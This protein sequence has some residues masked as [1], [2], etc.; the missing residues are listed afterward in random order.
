MKPSI[1]QGMKSSFNI[2]YSGQDTDRRCII[3]MPS[4]IKTLQNPVAITREK[5]EEID[6]TSKNLSKKKS[7]AIEIEDEEYLRLKDK[8]KNPLTITDAD[9][10]AFTGVLQDTN[11][12]GLNLNENYFVL[13]NMGDSFRMWP[14]KYWYRFNQKTSCDLT[15]EEIEM[16]MSKKGDKFKDYRKIKKEDKEIDYE[17]E[18]ADDS[19]NDVT[20]VEEQETELSNLGKELKKIMKN[21]EDES[22]EETSEDKEKEKEKE[23]KGDGSDKKGAFS[24][25]NI[26]RKSQKRNDVKRPNFQKPTR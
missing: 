20:L 22:S 17:E 11:V 10:K 2:I 14:I 4:D 18:F 13:I 26:K 15:L 16:R 5:S 23:T 9:Q 19:E 6:D 21:Y 1:L 12:A 3:T 7:E 25:Q 24:S 8:E